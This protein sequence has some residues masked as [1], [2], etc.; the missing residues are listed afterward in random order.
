MIFPYIYWL[1][2]VFVCLFVQPCVPEGLEKDSGV[3][4]DFGDKNFDGASGY[5]DKFNDPYY[6]DPYYDDQY[7][8]DQY[9]DDQYYDDPKALD[10][11]Y[12]RKEE[13]L[14]MLAQYSAAELQPLGHQFQ[15]MLMSCTYRGTKCGYAVKHEA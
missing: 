14:L 7:N 1:F 10:Q 9:Y 12:A 6:D 15:D 3:V 4:D 8:D 13:M 2:C 5:D 11:G